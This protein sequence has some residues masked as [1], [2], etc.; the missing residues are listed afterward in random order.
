[1]GTVKTADS[2]FRP[3]STATADVRLILMEI[4]EDYVLGGARGEN[5]DTAMY[6]IQLPTAGVTSSITPGVN[7][8]MKKAVS[9]R[10]H[11]C[12]SE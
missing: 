9:W 11:P 6:G 10:W 7:E 2:A 4:E 8:T 3:L 5:G 1:M 12:T